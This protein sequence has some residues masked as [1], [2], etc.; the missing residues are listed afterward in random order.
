MKI[1]K[2]KL[3]F[4]MLKAGVETMR[5]LSK[6]STV[7]PH[8]LSAITNGKTCRMDT[9]AKLAAALGVDPSEIIEEG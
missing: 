2:T 5:A 4:A 1:D 6:A 8:T 7:N 3:R 9:V